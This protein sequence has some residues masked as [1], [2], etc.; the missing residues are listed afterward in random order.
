MSEFLGALREELLD[1]LERFE[2]KPRRRVA[3]AARRLATAAVS[4][5]AAVAIALGLAER[6]PEVERGATPEVARL[7]GFHAT[8]HVVANG[9]LWVSQYDIAA[10]LRIDLATGGIRARIDVGGSPAAV[11]S[12]AGAVW[13][14]DWERGRLLELDAGTNRVVSSVA[15][16]TTNSDFTFA[17]GALWAIDDRGLLVRIDPATAAVT[18]RLSLGAA[19]PVPADRPSFPTLAAAGDTLWVAAA[20]GRVTELDA[21]TGDLLGR[22]RGPALPAEKARRAAADASGLWISSPTRREVVHIGAGTR[23][24]TRF[25][26]PGDPGPLAIVD[27]R[28]WVG[29]L[30]DTGSLTRL[31]VLEHDGRVAAT[32]PLPNLAVNIAAAPRG[33]AWVTFGENETVSPAALFVPDP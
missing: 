23:R 2:Q 33:G 7:E 4:A 32:V 27:G 11:L 3:P 30:H 19:A 5:A 25:A 16:G 29:T 20:D 10:V 18:R 15:V 31:T 12:A 8:G 9:D 17:A 26:V 22:A 14:H 6:A 1:G 24:V 28:I 21:R 13:V